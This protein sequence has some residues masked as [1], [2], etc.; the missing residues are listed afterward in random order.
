M[1][2]A[3]AS[4]ATAT[5]TL[6]A[7]T[8]APV[9]GPVFA[10]L[11]VAIALL[12]VYEHGHVTQLRWAVQ[13]PAVDEDAD[14]GTGKGL[15]HHHAAFFSSLGAGAAQPCAAPAA[16]S[17]GPGSQTAASSSADAASP[18]AHGPGSSPP[19]SSFTAAGDSSRS[20]AA[21]RPAA[22]ELASPF[23]Q[24]ECKS[25]AEE[26]LTAQQQST[27]ASAKLGEPVSPLPVAVPTCEPS[28]LPRRSPSPEYVS[29]RSHFSAATH[30]HSRSG[31][32]NS[33]GRATTAAAAA[34]PPTADRGGR[35]AHVG[36]TEVPCPAAAAA[37]QAALAPAGP[38]GSQ[39][40]APAQKPTPELGAA[41]REPSPSP[42]VV[43]LG[44]YAR[45]PREFW[46]F[47]VLDPAHLVSSFWARPSMLLGLHVLTA[48]YLAAVLLLERFNKSNLGP[49]WTTYFTHWAL[50]VFSL[51][52]AVAAINTARC[53]PLLV[54]SAPRPDNSPS[55]TNWGSS[56]AVR[57]RV[58]GRRGGRMQQGGGA[59][60]GAVSKRWAGVAKGEEARAGADIEHGRPS[61]RGPGPS[62][63]SI[64]GS[65]SGGGSQGIRPRGPLGA[66]A[67]AAAGEATT[68][69]NART[70]SSANSGT[71]MPDQ[72]QQPMQTP[73]ACD[74]MSAGP[75][76]TAGGDDLCATEQHLHRSQATARAADINCRSHPPHKTPE[77]GSTDATVNA[78]ANG[79]TAPPH[80]HAGLLKRLARTMPLGPL[81]AAAT[82]Q[83]RPQPG[84]GSHNIRGSRETSNASGRG[85]RAAFRPLGAHVAADAGLAEL[86]RSSR[87]SSFSGSSTGSSGASGAS[88]VYG[89]RQAPRQPP[90]T[91]TEAGLAAAVG[92]QEGAG[93]VDEES[94]AGLK[95]T[96]EG[97]VQHNTHVAPTAATS[98]AVH[99][100]DA[101]SV[102]GLKWD[103]L[104]VAHCLG[105]EVSVVTALF[106]T[107]VYWVG[108]VGLAGESF[109]TRSAPN[110]MKH[111]ANSGLA[112]LHVVAARLPLVSVHFTAF[113]L[114]LAAYCVFLWV[115]GEL[116]GVWRYGLNWTTPRGV[117]GEVVLVV[118]A[119][120]VFLLWYGVARMREHRG[121]LRV[122]R[123]GEFAFVDTAGLLEEAC[124]QA[125]G[126]PHASGAR[127]AMEAGEED[128][129]YLAGGGDRAGGSNV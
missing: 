12:P 110:Y 18:P 77:G 46:A 99:G 98:T 3:A 94:G 27:G 103:A 85:W 129:G 28:E 14:A 83:R 108:L 126:Q 81:A 97:Q 29:A 67:A 119:L 17:M 40:G 101:D 88:R 23:Q 76:N 30:S 32:G 1:S 39:E 20:S 47:D 49:W 8:H 13:L 113:L 34:D 92:G 48:L 9:L 84:A 54:S 73:P 79:S 112:L 90:G 124:G 93:D 109:D 89:L 55:R 21:T 45:H 50:A 71:G 114:F 24:V 65:I 70:D 57:A 128:E 78:S 91:G 123:V 26:E 80:P 121:R 117:A 52:A 74:N 60:T 68:G 58:E 102:P 4:P 104:S 95:A 69:T 11:I 19:A 63:S 38:E 31:S 7:K 10:V 107:L 5:T 2:A 43:G 116:S 105:L 115:Y 62:P 86:P 118:L 22:S 87:S 111:A 42:A 33:A 44:A 15:Q 61:T 41:P 56:L 120:L 36:A 59:V 125:E 16:G 6:G 82:A 106:V 96:P 35:R 64:S 75:R 51:S 37:A 25:R 53:L 100:H 122:I 127:H 66:A 72:Q